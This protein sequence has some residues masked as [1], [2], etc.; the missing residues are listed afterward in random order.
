MDINEKN[1][2]DCAEKVIKTLK[3]RKDNK[4][5]PVQMLT[6]SKI[7]NILAM[8][9][10]IYNEVLTNVEDTLSSDIQSR[11]DY[12]RVRFLYEAG[13]EPKVKDFVI[14]AG[15]TDILKNIGG[16]KKKYIL[17]YRYLESLVAFHRFYG[18][19]DN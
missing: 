4:D 7:R 8:S 14:E 19:K 17:F 10:D 6:T 9:A 13:R 5:R 16:S 3:E 15:L 1:Y 18:G 2:V 11:I 12:L